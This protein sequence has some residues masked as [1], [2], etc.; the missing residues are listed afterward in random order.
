VGAAVVGAAV[1]GAAV[2]GAAVV[3]AAVVGAA[4]VGA[5]VVGAAVVASPPPHPVIIKTQINRNVPNAISFFTICLPIYSVLSSPE[6]QCR[7]LHEFYSPSF[8]YYL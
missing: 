5:A 3:G 4:V 8:L 1:V 7:L 2:V 6:L